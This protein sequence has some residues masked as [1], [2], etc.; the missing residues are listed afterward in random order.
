MNINTENQPTTDSSRTVHS[1]YDIYN[2]ILLY[3]TVVECVYHAH[4][5][6]RNSRHRNWT[7][8]ARSVSRRRHRVWLKVESYPSYALATTS[9]S[10]PCLVDRVVLVL[11]AGGAYHLPCRFKFTPHIFIF[12]VVSHTT[13][14]SKH[15]HFTQKE[16]SAD[17]ST[18]RARRCV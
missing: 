10:C 1:Q 7:T 4:F 6:N 16:H 3:T 11:R 8:T 18:E 14:Q 13:H 17:G 5:N 2:S 9:F 12:S 15:Q